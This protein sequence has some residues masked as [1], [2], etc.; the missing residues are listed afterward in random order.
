MNSSLV[1]GSSGNEMQMCSELP[2]AEDGHAALP[3]TAVPSTEAISKE[4]DVFATFRS[5]LIPGGSLEIRPNG[6]DR[7]GVTGG[8]GNDHRDVSLDLT[9]G[10]HAGV[11]AEESLRP[12]KGAKITQLK[13]G[14]TLRAIEARRNRNHSEELPTIAASMPANVFPANLGTPAPSSLQLQAAGDLEKK[15]EAESQLSVSRVSKNSG[16]QAFTKRMENRAGESDPE[17]GPGA[18]S[19]GAELTRS[20]AIDSPGHSSARDSLARSPNASEGSDPR[21]ATTVESGDVRGTTASENPDT[22]VS[23]LFDQVLTSGPANAGKLG[24]ADLRSEREIA[25]LPRMSQSQ[26]PVASPGPSTAITQQVVS[27]KMS[28]SSPSEAV[29]DALPG[30]TASFSTTEGPPTGKRLASILDGNFMSRRSF[31]LDGPG[32]V[33]G[34]MGPDPSQDAALAHQLSIASSLNHASPTTVLHEIPGTA[35]L[36]EPFAVL[37]SGA[38]SVNPTWIHTAGHVAEAGYQ[39]P[40]LGWIGV[41]ASTDASGL[42]ASVVPNSETA[43]QTLSGHLAGLSSYLAEQHIPLGTISVSAP[44]SRS[45]GQGT[46]SQFGDE[47]GQNGEQQ[48]N[49]PQ[50]HTRGGAT[51][52]TLRGPKQGI[53]A[54]AETQL[55]QIDRARGGG[56]IS[57]IA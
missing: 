40:T 41:R 39:D 31:G 7:G 17:R 51:D 55:S 36:Q 2:V 1:S 52:F 38:G 18:Q 6:N 53:L 26:N 34:P 3:L 5:F 37:D 16:E 14:E 20:N 22:H 56:S 27:A 30:L 33:A 19:S 9:K 12:A 50:E 25:H 44:E 54:V 46:P 45:E 23:S 48:Q 8:A 4:A 13:Q 35:P 42:H 21:F 32:A 15:T 57:L 11:S 10:A 24:T 49:G 28:G 43:G 47:T 29:N